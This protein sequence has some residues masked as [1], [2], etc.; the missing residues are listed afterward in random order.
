VN[1]LLIGLGLACFLVPD[2]CLARPMTEHESRC[3]EFSEA[4]YQ[5][6]EPDDWSGIDP[7]QEAEIAAEL[8]MIACLGYSTEPEDEIYGWENYVC[9]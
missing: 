7:H 9:R 8:A 5:A 3:F 6:N 2:L 4:V 1:A